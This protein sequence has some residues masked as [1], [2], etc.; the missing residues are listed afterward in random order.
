M[1]KPKYQ[2]ATYELEER[3]RGVRQVQY[4]EC[5]HAAGCTDCCASPAGDLLHH[6]RERQVLPADVMYS[7]RQH[8]LW[9]LE[10]SRIIF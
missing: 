9:H 4:M 1:W 6:G 5:A 8:K 3:V 10:L 2:K 7:V